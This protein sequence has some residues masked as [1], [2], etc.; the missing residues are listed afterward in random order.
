[1]SGYACFCERHK[2]IHYSSQV[3]VQLSLTVQLAPNSMSHIDS[4][5]FVPTSASCSGIS[6]TV[7]LLVPP[8]GSLC[9]QSPRDMPWTGNLQWGQSG[10]LFFHFWVFRQRELSS[11]LKVQCLHVYDNVTMPRF[12]PEDYTGC[13]T[14]SCTS[15]ETHF[16]ILLYFTQ[17]GFVVVD[18]FVL[19][20]GVG[21]VLTV[22]A[23]RV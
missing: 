5:S 22:T 1:M 17:L 13:N 19:F 8:R 2:K 11:R 3:H 16:L 9:L 4:H 20:W 7:S 15:L 12:G 18:F 23:S 6:R 10:A 14:N 21:A